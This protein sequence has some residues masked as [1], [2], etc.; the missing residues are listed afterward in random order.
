MKFRV[1]RDVLTEGVTW[2][3][4][5]IASKPANLVLRGIQVEANTDGTVTLGAYD[6]E[7]TSRV[8]IAADV[9]EAGSVLVDGKMLAE[10]CKHLPAKPVDVALEDKS[11]HVECGNTSFSLGKMAADEFP[12]FPEMP[13]D[14][15][16]VDAGEWM[17]AVTQ[18]ATATSRDDTLPLLT[19][20][21]LEIEGER[22]SLLA[23]DR[24]RL[25]VKEMTWAPSSPSLEGRVLIRGSRLSEIARSF[26]GSGKIEIALEPGGS[27]LMGFAAA[28]RQ[29]TTRMID[30]DYPQVRS[31]FP[32]EINGHAVVDRMELLEA[33][34][35]SRI[36]VMQ[37]A[38]VRLAFSEGQVIV[39]GGQ[40][41]DSGQAKEVLEATL[42]G[43]DISMAFNPMY[44]QDT[45]S[46]MTSDF[47]RLSFTHASH[48][49]V[50]SEQDE[51]EGDDSTEFRVLLMPIRT[52]GAR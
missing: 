4:R 1:E 20:I 16:V 2:A 26:G 42:V 28:G 46:V 39:E 23:T 37:N 19:A 18:V 10:I 21:C 24:Y 49:A 13:A 36:V 52:F 38:A 5:V 11:L 45:L 32:K 7:I 8:E 41:G 50:V 33:I 47:V 40:G 29:S 15:G 14:A 17:E 27:N 25:A 30:G 22:V 9:E 34:R 48:P 12:S 51:M 6:P 31:L 3:A 35:R 43:E 44:L